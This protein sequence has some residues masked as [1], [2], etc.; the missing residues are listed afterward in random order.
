MNVIY[1]EKKMIRRIKGL[2]PDALI[3]SEKFRNY[4]ESVESELL[5]GISTICILNVINHYGKEGTYGYQLLKDL[6]ERTNQMLIIEE[7]TLYPILRKLEKMGTKDGKIQLLESEKKSIGG[8]SRKYYKLTEE[9]VKILH[10]LEG[11]FS[12]LIESLS[13][14][15][16]FNIELQ[17]NNFFFCPNC[18]NKIDLSHN[19]SNFCEMCGYPLQEVKNKGKTSKQAT[20]KGGQ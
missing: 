4:L 20:P 18:S 12:K 8:R 9:G 11:F 6:E 13:N 1:G 15:M 2:N 19:D 5:R 7:G 10:H 17:E 14:L 3:Q 16:N